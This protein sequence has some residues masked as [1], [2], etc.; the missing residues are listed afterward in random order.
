MSRTDIYGTIGP[1][2]GN[3]EILTEMFRLGMDGIRLNLSHGELEE[4]KSSY[5]RR[6]GERRG[7]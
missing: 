4:L 1:S 2:C 3:Q 7:S 6:A 5:A